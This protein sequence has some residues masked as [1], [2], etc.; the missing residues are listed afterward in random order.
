METYLKALTKIIRERFTFSNDSYLH[1][2]KDTLDRATELTIRRVFRSVVVKG[3]PSG[4]TE[5]HT[6]FNDYPKHLFI[7]VIKDR[8]V[9]HRK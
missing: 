2:L 7:M 4:V 3:L 5:I 8:T 6:N 1:R 9:L